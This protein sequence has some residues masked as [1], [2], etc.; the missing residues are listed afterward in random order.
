MPKLLYFKI[1]VLQCECKERK[2]TMKFKT[3]KKLFVQLLKVTGKTTMSNSGSG[4]WYQPVEP[5]VR[6]EKCTEIK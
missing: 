6:K 2:D 4:I 5:K 3:G 1:N